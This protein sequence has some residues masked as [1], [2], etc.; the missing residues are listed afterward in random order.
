MHAGIFFTYTR[1]SN[2]NGVVRS[3]AAFLHNDLSN[4]ISLDLLLSKGGSGVDGGGK[5]PFYALCFGY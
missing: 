1:I 2:L 5:V 3:S 4:L